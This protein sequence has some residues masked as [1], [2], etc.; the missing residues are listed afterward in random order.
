MVLFISANVAQSVV[1]LIRN[2]QVVRSSRIVGFAERHCAVL[3]CKKGHVMEKILNLLD[4]TTEEKEKFK[5]VQGRNEQIFAEFGVHEDGT[6]VTEK[7]WK[8]ATVI[9]GIPNVN[10]LKVFPESVKYLQG[11]MAGPDAFAKPGILPE[12]CMIAGC[13]G[14]YGQSVSEH[15]FAM[16]WSI[17]KKLPGY[18]DNQFEGKWED[19]GKCKTLADEN[20]MIIGTGDLGSSFA[21][22]C[23]S[24]GAHTFGIRRDKTKPA[25]GIDRMYSFE[26]ADS[27]IPEMDVII[28]MA[29]AGPLTNGF[30]TK[31]RLF[32]MKNDAIFLNGGRG[33]FVS[34]DD[35]YEVL[36]AGHLFGAGVDVL[37]REPLPEDH[38]LWKES[39]CLITP[40]KA[41]FDKIPITFR[42]VAAISLENL[43]C[44]L[45]GEELMNRIR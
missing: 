38:P 17:M 45:S 1:Q 18:R 9:V 16:M 30:M 37:D 21:K 10:Y 40:H 41:G 27:L 44:Y 31:E 34:S 11:K 13:Q 26:D 12:K 8:E 39:R 3:F 15:M 32:A 20:V 5:A 14:A 42:K 4:L 33:G 24:F 35:L 43:R 25:E 22:L 6:P 2:Q 7:E 36:H 23:K 29:P 28:N 19:L